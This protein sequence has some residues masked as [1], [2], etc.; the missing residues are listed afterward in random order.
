M[1]TI[2]NGDSACRLS[3]A[4]VPVEAT[5]ERDCNTFHW[6]GSMQPGVRTSEGRLHLHGCGWW[7]RG[8]LEAEP[9]TAGALLLRRAEGLNNGRD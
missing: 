2:S 3:E 1:M 5:D 8:Q 6:Y 7:P 4:Q 9:A